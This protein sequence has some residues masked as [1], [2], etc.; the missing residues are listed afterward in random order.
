MMGSDAKFFAC[1]NVLLSIPSGMFF[2]FVI[3]KGYYPLFIGVREVHDELVERT[4]I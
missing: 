2:V 1:T 4:F 3:P